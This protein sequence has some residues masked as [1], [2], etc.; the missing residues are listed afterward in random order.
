MVVV[1][2]GSLSCR[3]KPSRTLKLM[4]RPTVATAL[5]FE[6]PSRYCTLLTRRVAKGFKKVMRESHRSFVIAPFARLGTLC[7]GRTL[8]RVPLNTVGLQFGV[9]NL[10]VRWI[11]V[12]NGSCA[13]KEGGARPTFSSLT[14]KTPARYCETIRSSSSDVEMP[15]V[16]RVGRKR[17]VQD[18]SRHQRLDRARLQIARPAATDPAS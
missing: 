2:V 9:T 12:S 7:S 14:S 4:R 17:P 16:R 15:G 5:F 10:Q 11:S 3:S 1:G 8:R 13:G 6:N 18:K